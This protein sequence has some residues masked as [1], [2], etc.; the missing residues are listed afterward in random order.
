[1]KDKNFLSPEE[2]KSELAEMLA[3]LHNFL[4]ENGIEYSL[5]GGTLLGAIR[6]QGF[7][8]WD[9][10]IDILLTRENYKRLLSLKS[11]VRKKGS[12]DLVSVEDGSSEYPFI[13]LINRS[14]QVEQL[15]LRSEND[16]CLW[17]DIFPLDNVP[18]NAHRQK[19]LYTAAHM[20]RLM[21]E[22]A[23]IEPYRAKTEKKS[24]AVKAMLH[25]IFECIGAKKI[26]RVLSKVSQ[27]YNAQPLP[28]AG[29]VVWGYGMVETVRK[30]DFERTVNVQFEGLEL[31]AMSCWELYLSN[32]YG[33]YMTPPDAAKRVSHEVKAWRQAVCED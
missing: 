8:P 29:C 21:L 15:N 23:M 4:M 20:V 14:I 27:R 24:T 33:D 3:W 17:I 1:M 16:N 25:P 13:K 9:D 18:N 31:H 22:S 12:Y 10:D 5:A 2:I 30:E 11:E 7:I 19:G 32:L 6:H 28:N 26:S